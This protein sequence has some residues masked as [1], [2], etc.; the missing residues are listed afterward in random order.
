[1]PDWLIPTLATVAA[2]V[3]L[4]AAGSAVV[5]ALYRWRHRDRNR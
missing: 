1:M 2:V 3:A 5:I 4:C